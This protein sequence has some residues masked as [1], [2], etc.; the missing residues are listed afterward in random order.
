[1]RS[2]QLFDLRHPKVS[3]STFMQGKNNQLRGGMSIALHPEPGWWSRDIT[4]AIKAWITVHREHSEDSFDFVLSS[5]D[6]C[7]DDPKR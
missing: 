6:D 7:D 1:M 2:F 4:D 3:S 5:S